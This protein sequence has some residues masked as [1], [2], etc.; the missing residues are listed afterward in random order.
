MDGINTWLVPVAVLRDGC[1]RVNSQ[2][3]DW[4]PEDAGDV[5]GP[6]EEEPT[7]PVTD[8]TIMRGRVA[9]E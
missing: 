4:D 9:G 5:Q 6:Q 8:L 3:A 1:N 7:L 2:K